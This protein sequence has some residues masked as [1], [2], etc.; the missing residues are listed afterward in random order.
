MLE[1]G[2]LNQPDVTPPPATSSQAS[3]FSRS[4]AEFSLHSKETDHES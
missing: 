1:K 3:R 4:S 2:R